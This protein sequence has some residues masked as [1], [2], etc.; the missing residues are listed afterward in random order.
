MFAFYYTSFACR[1][2][3][4]LGVSE[5]LEVDIPKFWDYLAEMWSPVVY[6]NHLS[7]SSLVQMV[8]DAGLGH[9]AATCVIKYVGRESEQC[10]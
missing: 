7:L 5:D 9:K 3:E 2:V 8:H 1:C 10:G 6:S 4:L